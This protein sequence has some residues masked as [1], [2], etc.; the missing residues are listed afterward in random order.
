MVAAATNSPTRLPVFPHAGLNRTA[1]GGRAA[2]LRPPAE[3]HI[4]LRDT[5]R[6]IR[7][8][9]E[10]MGGDA[11]NDADSSIGGWRSRRR[12]AGWAGGPGRGG[13]GGCGRTRGGLPDRRGA[14]SRERGDEL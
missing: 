6:G 4:I 8:A 1:G 9:I 2:R 12:T 7:S 13:P 14:D 10:E 11:T 5:A 3:L